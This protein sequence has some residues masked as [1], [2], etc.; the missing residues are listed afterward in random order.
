MENT[1]AFQEIM[2]LPNVCG[3]VA[4]VA[5]RLRSGGGDESLRHHQH[6]YPAV[7]LQVVSDHKKIFWDVC[8]KAPGG[9]D[10]ST[11]LRDSL[12]YHRLTSGDVV[13]DKVVNV[14]GQHVRP[15]IVGGPDYPLLSFL[16]TPFTRPTTPAQREFDSA[17]MKGRSVVEEAIG[18][19]KGRWKI[20]RDLNVGLNHAPQTIVACCVLHN[21]CQIARE[22]EPELW[23]EADGSGEVARGLE[24]EQT[25]RF[26]GESLRQALADDL[27]QRISR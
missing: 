1:L 27:Y 11:H 6:G 2:E 26:Y 4:G 9:S 3:A 16:L 15:Y 24:S 21:L 19:L 10:N 18:L 12:L 14:R 8:V 5:V 20:L 7:L 22:P 17:L 23:S 25:S 13:W